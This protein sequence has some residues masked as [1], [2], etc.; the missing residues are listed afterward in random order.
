MI[1]HVSLRE[2][3]YAYGKETNPKD[4][5]HYLSCKD[6]CDIRPRT[7]VEDIEDVGT[8]NNA[9]YRSK[10]DFIHIQ[11]SMVIND[12]MRPRAFVRYLTL[13]LIGKDIKLYLKVIR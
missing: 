10:D 13:S 12:G 5:P 2:L 3:F 11:L 8:Q 7:W 6:I 1:S 4:D 9:K